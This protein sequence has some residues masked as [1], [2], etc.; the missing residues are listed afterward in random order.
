[1]AMNPPMRINNG[2]DNRTLNLMIQI[3]VLCHCTI[4][5]GCTLRNSRRS[6]CNTC[7]SLQN[8]KQ[9]SSRGGPLICSLYVSRRSAS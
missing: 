6:H 3:Q 1:M 2:R 5:F 8:K 4:F 7:L 9:I